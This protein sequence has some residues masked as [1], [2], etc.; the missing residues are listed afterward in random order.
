MNPGRLAAAITE[1]VRVGLATPHPQFDNCVRIVPALPYFLRTRLRLQGHLQAAVM[2]A[3]YQLYITI[4]RE[5]HRLLLSRDPQERILGH[6][7]TQAEYANLNRR[8]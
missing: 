1:A 4:G 3:H 7:A 2:Q 5:L 8:P 6:L